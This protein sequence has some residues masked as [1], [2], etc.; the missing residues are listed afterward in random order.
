MKKLLVVLLTL[1]LC[2]ATLTSCDF[3][4]QF[5]ENFQLL[6]G[7]SINVNEAADYIYN[8]YKDM[9]ITSTDY[10]LSAKTNIG[11]ISYDIT[12]SVNTDKVKI[13]KKDDNTYLVNVDERS[14]EDVP[15]V[16]TAVITA[17]DRTTAKK[18]FN[19]MVPLYD[20][21]SHEEY[22]AAKKD[23]IVTIAGI[24]V[25]INSKEAGNTRNHLFLADADVTGGYYCY[26][27]KQ[28]PAKLGIEV[29]MTVKV[30]GPVTPYGDMQEIKDGEIAILDKTIKKVDV[31]DITEKFAAG[32][33]LAAYIGLPV[34]IKGVEIGTQVL[35]VANSQYL[36]FKLNG[37]T[38]Y[39]R[40]YITDFPTTLTITTDKDGN[41]IGSPDK[42]AIDKAHAEHFGWEAN[43]TGVL[44][45]YGSD[46]YLVPM[47]VDCFEYIKKNEMTA[48]KAIE[49]IT[50][51]ISTPI[52]KD[53]L[54]EL[55][56]TIKTYEDSVTI[57]WKS[58]TEG[59]AIVDNKIDI[60]LGASATTLKLV[61]TVTC[62]GKTTEKE[63]TIEIP[64]NLVLSTTKPYIPS[65]FQA[66]LDGGKT[67]YLDG[68]FGERYLNTTDDATKAVAVY[69]ELA[70][71]GYKFYILVDG[72]KNYVYIY[73]NDAGKDSVKYDAANAS[74]FS[75]NETVNAW[76]ADY[77]NGQYYLGTY[78][79]YNTVS[80]SN[81]SYINAENTGVDQFPLEYTPVVEGVALNGTLF[82][83]KLDGGKTLYLDGTFGERYLNTTN[84]ITKA[85]AI[86][87][88]EAE[89][90]YK[91]YILVDG[92]KNYLYLY[93]NDAG[94]SAVKFDAENAN[95][96]KFDGATNAWATV[97]DG[98][99]Y[100]LGTYNT[101][102]TVSSSA[103][104]YINAENTGIDQFPLNYIIATATTG[105]G[106]GEGENPPAVEDPAA[107]SKLSVKEAA[108]LGASKEHNVYTEGKYF[109]TGEILS[110]AD[111][112]YGNMTIKDTD[113]NTL[114]LY[115]LYNIDGTIRFDAMET[116]PAVGDTIT[117]YGI[118]GQ[119]SSKAQMKK[120]WLVKAPA[121]D[122]TLSL[123][124]ANTLGLGCAHNKYTDDQYYVTGEIVSI[125]NTTYGNMIIEDADGN[126]LYLYGL[127][128]GE[129][130]YGE[131]EVKPVVGDTVTMYGVIGQ[132]NGKAQMNN[133]Q[134]TA[135]VPAA[136]AV[137][138][139]DTLAIKATEGTLAADSLSIA[140]AT[141]NFNI[142]VE[143]NTSTT[144]INVENY[145]H[146]RCYA[147]SKT[148]ITGKNGQ[149]ITKV[150]ITVTESKYASVLVD[151]ATAAGY[152]ASADGLVITITVN[153]ATLSYSN[154]KQARI[155]NIEIYY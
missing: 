125:D 37:K 62:N 55:P 133:G 95:V 14:P 84:D 34:T 128:V 107:N 83:A 91:F 103:L 58:N 54:L 144:A 64:A 89:G 23:E 39:V 148:T 26:Q 71:G 118:L 136:P 90:G 149:T 33:S 101:Y 99:D 56:T 74:V 123:I 129:K 137:E 139:K 135:H 12:W 70:E 49:T 126:T 102:N 52:S 153:S 5:L 7:D 155:N 27:T 8:V 127:K 60:K 93:K 138:A 24:V 143:K 6:R 96:F 4:N 116:T 59:F 28:D 88:E 119:Y 69:A 98:G 25:A 114:Y 108:E 145:D 122:S 46:Y 41:A 76:V 53:T 17:L 43:A 152:T 21:I 134:M 9:S 97:Y 79:T 51:E 121:A 63:F 131:L 140:W 73:K 65:L 57:S 124:G 31:L 146:F 38:A 77:N 141:E 81:V 29:G 16:L 94:K 120:G 15:Y 105:E 142:L 86:Y 61:A 130:K 22:M 115:G 50:P 67:L 132:Y 10:E 19:L 30:T 18:Q 92:A 32:E 78:N 75:Y 113:G 3:A 109:V 47:S 110:I 35:E 36:Y 68:T 1:V 82:Q 80:V 111:T 150:V 66:K 154:V 100:Y 106:E 117:V 147:G 2:V 45:M 72:A 40:T 44:V 112:T 48:E 87:A 11:G 151:N 13:T 42:D 104:S 20:A 85:V